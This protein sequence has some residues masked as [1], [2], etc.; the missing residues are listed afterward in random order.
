MA[1]SDSGRPEESTGSSP[2]RR[3]AKLL[4]EWLCLL[5]CLSGYVYFST[6]VGN[7]DTPSHPRWALASGPPDLQ[8]Q[9]EDL[10]DCVW[11]QERMWHLEDRIR[12]SGS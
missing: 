2:W 4:Y 1:R 12:G 11:R 9:L 7:A 6:D 5:S 8:T 3:V 10:F